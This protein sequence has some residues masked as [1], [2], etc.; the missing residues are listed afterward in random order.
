MLA[1]IR[2]FVNAV[3]VLSVSALA[4]SGFAMYF[5]AWFRGVGELHRVASFLF[6]AA[7]LVHLVINRKAL[8]LGLKT[9]WAAM[10]VLL[11]LAVVLLPSVWRHT[12]G[13]AQD[14]SILKI[15]DI[16][17]PIPRQ[18]GG[19]PLLQSLKER[20]STRA[21]ADKELPDQLV[22]DLMWAAFGI[23]RENLGKRTAPSAQNMQEIEIYAL[24]A[25][26][27]YVYD[28]IA[29]RLRAVAQGDWRRVAAAQG[30][31]KSVPLVLAY[32]A[33]RSKAAT[34]STDDWR[35][36]SGV[37]TG[38]ISQNVYLFCSS[39]G[40]ATVVLGTVDR[41]ALAATLRLPPEKEVILTQPVGY[42]R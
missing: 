31:A 24:R 5:H 35:R 33:D 16:S 42:P 17:L 19:K 7:T 27:A 22:A 10:A 40:L 14:L 30:F 26:G 18:A 9:R 37:D 32:V 15:A 8:W 23:N 2:W 20:Q 36:Y 6:I 21:F 1:K 25:D 38:F 13:K 11:I 4:V 34:A 28:P 41:K 39:E 29:N 3:L 12:P